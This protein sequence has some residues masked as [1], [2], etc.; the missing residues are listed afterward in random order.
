VFQAR[1]K[2]SDSVLVLHG[3][4]NALPHSRLGISAGRRLGNAVARNRWKRLIREAFRKQQSQIPEGFDFVA[5]PQP[6]VDASALHVASSL[7]ALA[8]KLQRRESRS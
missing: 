4:A 3:V 2:V 8:R 6:G 7:L 5:R 1:L